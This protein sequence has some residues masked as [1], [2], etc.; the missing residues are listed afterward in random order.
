MRGRAPAPAR[1]KEPQ[2][3]PYDRPTDRTVDVVDLLH[4]VDG[5]EPL[6]PQ[7][8]VKVVA[9]QTRAGA[10]EKHRPGEAIGAALGNAIDLSATERIFGRPHRAEI[11]DHF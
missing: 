1:R 9:L 5:C 2:P 10:G 11:D 4:G 8:V 3:I 7:V 6:V